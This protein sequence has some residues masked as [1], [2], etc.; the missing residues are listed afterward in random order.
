MISPTRTCRVRRSPVSDRP[1]C[2]APVSGSTPIARTRL[3]RPSAARVGPSR[4]V[5]TWRSAQPATSKRPPRRALDARL[6]RDRRTRRAA[7]SRSMRRPPD[8]SR[9]EVIVAGELRREVGRGP[10]GVDADADDD[11]RVVRPETVG[12]AEDAGRAC[13]PRRVALVARRDDEVVRPLEADR[14]GRQPGG[15]LGGLG[16]RERR[17]GG[18]PP[19]LVRRAARSGRNP[20][21]QQQRGARRRRPSVRPSRPRPAVCSSA[22]ARQTSGV[23]SASQ[24]RTTSFVEPTRAKSLAAGR[25][26]SVIARAALSPAGRGA[27]IDGL[28]SLEL[29]RVVQR[30]QGG[31][32][33]VL[34]D[35]AGDPD[36]GGR[37]HLDV[38]AGV[39]ERP[40]HPRGVAR[41]VVQPGADDRHL[42]D[43]RVGRQLAGAE[44]AD[45][46][47]ERLLGRA[48]ARP[49]GR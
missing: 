37:D 36:L 27:G 21:E 49:A 46:R 3:D 41:R 39:G 44:L 34:G 9:S 30:A 29:E 20:S 43:R 4:P 6:E 48:P 26:T 16:H 13:G 18:Q 28:G 1:R 33:V 19:D 14:P 22:T 15:R 7:S 12:L 45:E 8:A 24:S 17:D 38:D 5:V 42:G 47:L 11:A 25:G 40:E 31:L 35:H 32:E 2:S 10:V 23:P